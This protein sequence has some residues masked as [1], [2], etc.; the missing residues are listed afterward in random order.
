M[1]FILHYFNTKLEGNM[2]KYILTI[3]IILGLVNFSF[4][5]PLS[6]ELKVMTDLLQSNKSISE[7]HKYE[8]T[9]ND[10]KG[11]PY[12][13]DEF[14]N[15]SIFTTQRLQ[16]VDIPLRYNIYNDELEFKTPTDEIMALAIPEIVE[17]AVF[18]ETEMVYSPFLQG[19]KTKKGFFILLEE[20]KVS[21]YAK[22]DVMFKKAT[23]PGAF[24]D[25]E[26]PKFLKKSDEYYIRVG[27][28]QAQIIGN[29]KD[30][31]AAFPDNQDK[32]ESFMSNN[33]TKTGKPE[34]LKE[35]VKYYNSL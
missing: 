16:Y 13:N 30:L 8:L 10:I 24:K 25:P 26:P 4:A 1:K 3:F 2:K 27:S 22:P 28:G 6:Y 33:K 31:I 12:L 5:Q 11:S 20:G 18:G 14:I 35:L 15:G 29:K 34:S 9:E 17:K 32:I 7:S 21:L 19:N 23:Q